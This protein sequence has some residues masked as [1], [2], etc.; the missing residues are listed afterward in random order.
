MTR[1]DSSQKKFWENHNLIKRRHPS[2]PVIRAFVEPKIQFIQKN[3]SLAKDSTLLDVG[4]GN[5]FFTY[6]FAK[7]CQVTGLD[8]SKKMLEINP[9]HKLV[10]GDAENL[11]FPDESFD[12]TFCSNLLHH[13]ENP[14]RTMQEM[15]RVAR[16]YVIIS[17]PNRSNPFLFFFDLIKKEERGGL[18]FT[19]NYLINL[20]RSLGLKNVNCL[21]SGMIFPNKTP[22]NLLPILKKLDFLRS[23]IL[24]LPGDVLIIAVIVLIIN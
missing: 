17:E 7:I 13:L 19:K 2:H 8:F 12:I 11:P 10:H 24:S 4:C 18:K 22:I 1:Y 6:Y 3:I 5:G 21:V 23:I 20:G 15:K 14:E 16:E 9:H